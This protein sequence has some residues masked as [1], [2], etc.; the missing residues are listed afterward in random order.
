LGVLHCLVLGVGVAWWVGRALSVEYGVGLS[1]TFA[2]LAGLFLLYAVVQALGLWAFALLAPRLRPALRPVWLALAYALGEWL[3]AEPGAL[4]WGLVAHAVARTPELLA[5]AALGGVV[6]AGVPIVTFGALLGA[7]LRSRRA[8]PA[9][10]AAA[11]ALAVAGFGRIWTSGALPPADVEV[12]VVQAAVPQAE[13][14]RP[15]SALRNT[16][17]HIALSQRAL[18]EA[19]ADLLVWSETAVDD[20]LESTPA[21]RRALERLVRET[22]TPL[23]TGAPRRRGA[24]REN[25]VVLITPDAGLVES[26]AKQRLVPFAEYDPDWGGLIAP[27]LGPVTEGPGYA[28]GTVPQLLTGGPLPIGTPICFEITYPDLV[29]GF[30]DAGAAL[31]VNLSNDAWFG[32]TGYAEYHLRHAIARAVETHSWVVRG[33]NTGISAIVDPNGRV[34]AEL[35]LFEQ[36][37]L[38]GRVGARGTPTPYSWVGSAPLWALCVGVLAVGLVPARR[39]SGP[40]RAERA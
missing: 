36:G 5:P 22:G 14:F 40:P 34:V 13:R 2:V 26:Y 3:R 35:A 30:E 21:L 9:L 24:L 15:G 39:P 4:P 18:S 38:R 27:L 31:L 16:Q 20:E 29:R 23:V 32:R 33:A 11:V 17:R 8:A 28:A 37:V 12:V 6:F 7:S 25:A 10:A 1:A 19:P